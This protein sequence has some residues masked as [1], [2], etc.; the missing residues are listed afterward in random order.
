MT[1]QNAT[2]AAAKCLR[3]AVIQIRGNHGLDGNLADARRWILRACASGA[4]LV[5]LP[6]NFAYF[7]TKPLAQAAAGEAAATGT[8]RRF[9]ADIAREQGIWLVGGT[10]PVVDSNHPKFAGK[11]FARCYLLSPDGIE[12]AYYDKMHLFDVN[13][14]ETGKLYLESND[15][16][17][18]DQVVVAEANIEEQVVKLG[19]SVCY[20]LRFP[21]LYRQQLSLGAEILTAPSAFTAAT[22]RAHWSLLLR[23]RAVENL[24]FMLAANL[25]DREHAKTPTWGG[26]AIIDPWGRVLAALDDGEGFAIADLDLEEQKK[27]RVNMPVLDHRRIF[28]V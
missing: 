6:E 8:A 14:A 11:P 20:D 27:I 10:I 5:V 25:G 19:L 26:S 15:Y 12:V 17:R 13:V 23:A 9:L 18:G 4:Q 16:G 21:E 24:C 2:P 3:A 7:G 28:T 22:G 1:D